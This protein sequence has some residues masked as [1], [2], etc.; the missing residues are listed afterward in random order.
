MEDTLQYVIGKPVR[1]AGK[2]CGEVA[3]VVV[4]PLAR[5]LTH[6]VVRPDGGWAQPRLV[7]VELVGAMS[8]VVELSCTEQELKAL[9]PAEETYFVHGGGDVT[10]AG[11]GADGTGGT[12]AVMAWPF[13]GLGLSP[14]LTG[15]PGGVGAAV[16]PEIETV[17]R[18]PAG[19]VE[20]RRGERVHATDGEIGR[21]KGLVV[22]QPDSQVTHVLLDEGHLWGR[23]CVAIPIGA[24]SG[25]DESGVAVRLSKDEIR[26][27]PPVDVEG[28]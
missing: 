24:V 1:C 22:V 15:T 9:E 26:D 16:E 6:L 3:Y 17:R 2:R 18:I 28:L 10:P 23:R 8:D 12:A 25:I 4:D 5:T 14:L 27:L 11:D 21:V 20:V 13:Y 19:E 7:P